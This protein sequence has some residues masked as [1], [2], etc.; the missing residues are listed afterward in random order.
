VGQQQEEK[1][2]EDHLQALEQST[3]G[4]LTIHKSNLYDEEL[5]LP[6]LLEHSLDASHNLFYKR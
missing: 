1:Y 3:Q 6:N 4:E 2:E 5:E